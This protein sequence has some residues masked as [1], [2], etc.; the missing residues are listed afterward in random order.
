MKM[1]FVFLA[2]LS[3]RVGQAV[4]NET[5]TVKPVLAKSTQA[6]K[7]P[8]VAKSQSSKAR[9]L[10]S[11]ENSSWPSQGLYKTVQTLPPALGLHPKQVIF[12]GSAAGSW[13]TH[14][15]YQE[16]AGCTLPQQPLPNNAGP[17]TPALKSATGL[18]GVFLLLHA[19]AYNSDDWFALPEEVDM[20]YDLLRRGFLLAVPD[21][22]QGSP[23]GCW[24]PGWNT[25]TLLHS[26]S[27]FRKAFGLEHLP[28]YAV[29]AS[30]GGVMLSSLVAHGLIF[31]GTMF[32]VSPGT[33]NTFAIK[34]HPRSAF[35]FMPPDPFG[36]K[37]YIEG[38]VTALQHNGVHGVTF[39]AERKPIRRLIERAQAM[40][41]DRH[42]MTQM[43]SALSKG[44]FCV[45]KQPG[46][47][48]LPPGYSGSAYTFLVRRYTLLPVQAKALWEE[49]R[50]I[51]GVHSPTS[52][53]FKESIDFLL[54]GQQ[55]T[56]VLLQLR[57]PV[58]SAEVNLSF[59]LVR[60]RGSSPYNNSATGLRA[61]S[62]PL[63]H[64]VNSAATLRS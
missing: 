29:G 64:R 6:A 40:R 60:N 19:C 30:S 1:L 12:P 2:L 63:L 43:V 16:P 14:F 27:L 38:A 33:A 44:R 23:G 54:T 21:A 55:T 13:P 10:N 48:Y 36:A 49:L 22:I 24:S 4:R 20:V 46:F 35:V 51:E 58:E 56:K 50:V 11:T 15:L 17:L 53:H 47:C 57:T 52:E 5:G 62:L 8:V 25:L 45:E 3:H 31:A 39:E 9:T 26:F 41:I 61:R 42:T 32:V 28:L 7:I 37:Q 34:N 18:H 59:S